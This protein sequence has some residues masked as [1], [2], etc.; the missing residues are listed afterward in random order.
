MVNGYS[1]LLCPVYCCVVGKGYWEMSL[2][3]LDVGILHSQYLPW[4]QG[5][6]AGTGL[7]EAP[8]LTVPP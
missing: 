8:F 1:D 6:Y 4:Q 7:P 3:H 5:F 2:D